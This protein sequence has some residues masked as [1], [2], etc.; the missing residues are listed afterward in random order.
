MPTT[1]S[2]T[3]E[4]G[5]YDNTIIFFWS[6]HGVGL[7]GKGG[8]MIPAPISLNRTCTATNISQTSSPERRLTV[9]SSIDLS[10]T[11]LNLGNVGR[12]DYMRAAFSGSGTTGV[13]SYMVR[14]IEWTSGMT[15]FGWYEINDLNIS[16]ITT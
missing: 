8:F 12:P 3:Q 13:T 4:A 7:P 14:G 5:L 15:L 10:A 6:D 1:R 2:G 9:L 16:A 11:V